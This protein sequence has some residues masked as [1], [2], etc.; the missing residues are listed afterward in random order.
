MVYLTTTYPFYF[1]TMG[2]N[3]AKAVVFEINGLKLDERLIYPDEDYVIYAASERLGKPLTDDQKRHVCNDLD[4]FQGMWRKS[5]GF[6]G[7][8]AY[9]G[10][11]PTNAITRY[12]LFDP[13]ARPE[14]AFHIM[15]ASINRLNHE[16]QGHQY[17]QIIEWCFGDRKRLPMVSEAKSDEE[18]KFWVAQSRDRTGIQ[19]KECRTTA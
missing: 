7:N 2:G 15:D 6:L 5:L 14:L 16:H 3:D 1:A 8:C 11:I 19:V 9:G 4:L 17:R 13:A 12:C 10:T 18:R